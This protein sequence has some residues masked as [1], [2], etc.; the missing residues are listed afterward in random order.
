MYAPSSLEVLGVATTS[1]SL[2]WVNNSS[3]Q[4]GFYVYVSTDGIVYNYLNYSLTSDFTATG[5]IPDTLYYF[6]VRAFNAETQSDYSDSVSSRTLQS[7][8]TET[9][10]VLTGRVKN[11]ETR[12]KLTVSGRLIQSKDLQING[13]DLVRLEKKLSLNPSLLYGIQGGKES[14]AFGAKEGG[15]EGFF[16]SLSNS[17]VVTGKV[18]GNINSLQ[19]TGTSSPRLNWSNRFYGATEIK[20]HRKNPGGSYQVV[21]RLAS[22]STSYTDSQLPSGSYL[23]KVE[24]YAPRQSIYSAEVEIS[25]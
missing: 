17:P 3:T 23:Y 9:P 7:S 13:T 24:A 22:D 10:A 19:V 14:E 21:K 6:K 1:I 8:V 11:T 5:L 16:D 15:K 25:T 4:I 2:T 18:T 12:V 20:I